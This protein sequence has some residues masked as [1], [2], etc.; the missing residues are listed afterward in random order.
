MLTLGVMHSYNMLKKNAQGGDIT[1]P[2]SAGEYLI[3]SAEASA[4]NLVLCASSIPLT[5]SHGHRRYHCGYNES[6]LARPRADV[7][8]NE[9]LARRVPR[10]LACVCPSCDL[11]YR[12]Y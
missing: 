7:R 4:Y 10:A 2:M 11:A 1:K 9:R 12:K 5:R 3:C 8:F 6:F